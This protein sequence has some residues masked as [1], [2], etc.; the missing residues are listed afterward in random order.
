MTVFLLPGSVFQPET[1]AG[2][3]GRCDRCLFET[4]DDAGQ[5]AVIAVG[6]QLVASSFSLD[7]ASGEGSVMAR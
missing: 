5:L 4:N 1:L 6:N 7:F 3:T 2:Y